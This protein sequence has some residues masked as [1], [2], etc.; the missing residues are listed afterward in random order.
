MA[1]RKDRLLKEAAKKEG[2]M[3]LE[4][5]LFGNFVNKVNDEQI[6]F[7][8]DIDNCEMS[9]DEFKSELKKL[10]SYSSTYYQLCRDQYYSIDRAP[11]INTSFWNE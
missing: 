7:I 1:K 5:I 6:S 3:Q 9:L 4:S 10:N 11:H 2:G 8:T